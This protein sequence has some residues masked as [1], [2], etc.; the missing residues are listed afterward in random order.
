MKPSRVS[1]QAAQAMPKPDPRLGKRFKRALRY[2]LVRVLLAV[3][4]MFSAR[5]L[6]A[7]GE[8]LGDLAFRFVG[9]ER[10]RALQSLEVAFPDLSGAERYE[11][12]RAA[13]QHLGRMA[14][15]LVRVDELDAHVDDWVDWSASSRAV[16]DDAL[17]QGKGVVFVSGHVGSW[18]LLARRVSLAGYPA[19]TI[20]KESP[21]FRLTALVEQLRSSGKLNT[22]WRGR[23]GA[24]RAMLK[25]LKSGGILGLLIDQDT[26]VQSVF[27]P[28]FGR[29]AKTPRAAA[30]L[31]LRARAPLVLGFCH[32]EGGKYVLSMR[33][34]SLAPYAHDEAGVLALTAHLT[35]E[36]EA[37]IRVH[38]EQWVWMH[39]R[40]RSKPPSAA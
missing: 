34:V 3:A 28:F 1:T 38:P 33:E 37:A 16:L 27:V 10:N 30:D 21:D 20:A 13:F 36:I 35:R 23:P 17:K 26:D 32:R 18:E 24:A 12:A 11:L 14:G 8:W 15:E 9:G 6:G 29:D 2:G 5:T 31:A 39:R 4:R 19:T 22:I 7:L 40:W 25:V